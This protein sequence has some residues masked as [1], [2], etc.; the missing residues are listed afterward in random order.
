M[1]KKSLISMFLNN[2]EK[3]NVFKWCKNHIVC[4]QTLID[5]WISEFIAKIPIKQT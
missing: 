4:G 5:I 2:K 3:I 1:S